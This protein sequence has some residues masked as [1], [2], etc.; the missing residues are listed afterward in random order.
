MN[1]DC[2]HT[3]SILGAFF[4]AHPI[5]DSAVV[6]H[7]PAGC[8]KM[9]L[10]AACAHDLMGFDHGRATTSAME[11]PDAVMGGADKLRARIA[12]LRKRSPKARVFV[13]SCCVPEIVGD[14]LADVAHSFPP[15]AVIV[16]GGAGFRGGLWAGFSSALERI[17]QD[18][19]TDQPGA[20]PSNKL[21]NLVGYMCDRQEQDHLANLRIL[22]E[23]AEGIGLG[24]NTVFTGPGQT[25]GL[26]RAWAAKY[27]VAFDY[28]LKAAEVLSRRYGQ[29]TV[30]AVYP[31]GLG[32]SS[33]FLRKL[34]KATGRAKA[35]EAYISAQL[36]LAVPRIQA[37]RAACLGK[38]VGVCA[39]SQKLPALVEFLRDLGMRPAWVR[40]SDR[41]EEARG[42][43][44]ADLIVGS[45][46]E[47][48]RHGERVPVYEF[49]YPC[50]DRH[51]LTPEPDL[52]FEG[53]VRL[54]NNLANL[55][56]RANT[57]AWGLSRELS[58]LGFV[59]ALYLRRRPK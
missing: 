51:C 1:E 14:D 15:G 48:Y 27:N 43:G 38:R 10:Y 6:F 23:L 17:A 35:A 2:V 40:A 39:E 9:A 13:V 26:R 37:L 31:I 46:V 5:R 21:I 19:C 52:G 34:G 3:C 11:G 30:H 36:R 29:S 50:F 22:R 7:G 49:T 24:L 59:P 20:A 58:R 45:S 41:P 47:K 16:L 57:R 44:E 18:L 42:S 28:G 12:R 8:M 55:L 56:T 25:R 32:G 33:A 53:A 54:A 4:A